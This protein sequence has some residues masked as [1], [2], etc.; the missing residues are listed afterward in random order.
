MNELEHVVAGLHPHVL[1]ISEANF[2]KN[3][4]LED[5]QL[6][7]YDLNLSKT[8]ENE[9]LNISRIACYKHNSMVGKVRKEDLLCDKFS[10]I[11]A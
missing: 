8:I 6:D 1:G 9:D 11:C 7:D 4:D 3:H 5:V 2:K 10:S